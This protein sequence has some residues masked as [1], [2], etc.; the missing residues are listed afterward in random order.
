MSD[1]H[2][3]CISQAQVISPAIDKLIADFLQI[4][5]GDFLKA[6]MNN[7]I[8]PFYVRKE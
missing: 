2:R 4:Q 8:L 5:I 3:N 6:K 1:S 7:G